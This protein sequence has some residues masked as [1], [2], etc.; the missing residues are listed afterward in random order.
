MI[1]YIAIETIDITI[2]NPIV[3]P[4]IAFDVFNYFYNLLFSFCKSIIL[5]LFIH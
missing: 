3:H 5:S 4:N 2:I 1:Q